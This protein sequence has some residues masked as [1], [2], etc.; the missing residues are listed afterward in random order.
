VRP[1]RA[2][3]PIVASIALFQYAGQASLRAASRQKDCLIDERGNQGEQLPF[4]PKP[5]R[6]GVSISEDPPTK[7]AKRPDT[8][9]VGLLVSGVLLSF[10]VAPDESSHL[11]RRAVG[12]A[13][14]MATFVG[15]WGVAG[16]G[17]DAEEGRS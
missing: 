10:M 13:R 2:R 16:L 3:S 17:V 7:R 14:Q 6:A 4:T 1:L 12:P 8:R 5:R 9:G 15:A 11:T